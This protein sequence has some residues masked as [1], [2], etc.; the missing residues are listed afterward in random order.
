MMLIGG[1]F[2]DII[3]P[4]SNQHHD[5]DIHLDLDISTDDTISNQSLEI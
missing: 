5:L 1:W 4:S 3:E 2:N